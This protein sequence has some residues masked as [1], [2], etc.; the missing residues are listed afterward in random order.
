MRWA[1]QKCRL[2]AVTMPVQQTPDPAFRILH[3]FYQATV[4]FL[5][6]I[7]YFHDRLTQLSGLYVTELLSSPSKP[8]KFKVVCSHCILIPRG[9]TESGTFFGVKWNVFHCN[10]KIST[11]N[12]VYTSAVTAENLPI[13]GIGLPIL[14]FLCIFITASSPVSHSYFCPRRENKKQPWGKIVQHCVSGV[15]VDQLRMK[16]HMPK[17]VHSSLIVVTIISHIIY[18]NVSQTEHISAVKFT[19]VMRKVWVIFRY[20]ILFKCRKKVDTI[21][22]FPFKLTGLK[23]SG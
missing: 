15:K 6:K 9:S 12:S 5:S 10:L 3:L 18:T 19:W 22:T 11:S 4:K 2:Q 23:W 13:S 20:Q 14:I 1:N 17:L 7:K 8:C 21:N 16:I